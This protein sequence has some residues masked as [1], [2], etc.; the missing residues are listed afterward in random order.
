VKEI[1]TS[2]SPSSV[3]RLEYGAVPLDAWRALDPLEPEEL[4]RRE[5]RLYKLKAWILGHVFNWKEQK[6][7]PYASASIGRITDKSRTAVIDAMEHG[8][9]DLSRDEEAPERATAIAKLV[10]LSLY[11]S[12]MQRVNRNSCYADLDEA[13]KRVAHAKAGLATPAEL[14]ELLQEYPQIGSIELA[15]LSHPLDWDAPF[16]MDE[17][18][19]KTVSDQLGDLHPIAPAYKAKT[20]NADVPALTALRKQTIG[21]YET[22]EGPLHVVRRQAF[23]VRGDEEAQEEQNDGHLD[24]KVRNRTQ[25]RKG[26]DPYDRYEQELFPLVEDTVHMLDHVPYAKFVQPLA[27]SYYVKNLSTATKHGRKR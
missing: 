23:L 19:Y 6:Q 17:D 22:Q 8:W 16:A 14:L 13:D 10:E 9:V 20:I 24:R 1:I 4:A 27:T 2:E 3:R 11:D 21:M 18:V 25:V 7:L 26:E 5:R 12:H 15:K